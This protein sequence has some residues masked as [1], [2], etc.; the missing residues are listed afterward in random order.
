[1]EV[2]FTSFDG[3]LERFSAYRR[4]RIRGKIRGFVVGLHW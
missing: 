1:M 4:R 3:Y 2:D